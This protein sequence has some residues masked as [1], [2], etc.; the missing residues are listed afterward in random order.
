MQVG[1]VSAKSWIVYDAKDRRVIVGKKVNK[2][3]EVASLTKIM[4]FYVCL[5]TLSRYFLNPKK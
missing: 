4:N 5:K 1:D 3:L 2:K